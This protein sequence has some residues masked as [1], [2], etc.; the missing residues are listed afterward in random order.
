VEGAQHAAEVAVG[1]Q[2]GLNIETPGGPVGWHERKAEQPD[3]GRVIDEILP[4]GT[5][6]RELLI[7]LDQVGPGQGAIRQR[8]GV[9]VGMG[10]SG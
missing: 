3:Q 2:A 10:L 7:E 6:R 9:A 1:G 4:Q 5:H 8:R